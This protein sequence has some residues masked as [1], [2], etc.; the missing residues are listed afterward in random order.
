MLSGETV[1]IK[2]K[3]AVF[4]PESVVAGTRLGH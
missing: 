2:P 3:L 1:T 4:E